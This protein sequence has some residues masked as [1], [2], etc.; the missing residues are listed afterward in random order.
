MNRKTCLHVIEGKSAAPRLCDTCWSGVIMR[1]AKAAEDE[2]FCQFVSR[3]IANDIISC[4]RYAER[5]D[6]SARAGR[7]C[8]SAWVA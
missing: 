7:A 8:D 5:D 1:S 2:V 6:S 3:N 4:D